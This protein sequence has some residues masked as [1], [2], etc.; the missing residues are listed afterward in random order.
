MYPGASAEDRGGRANG[1]LERCAARQV[2]H[3]GARG[4]WDVDLG[5][6]VGGDGDLEVELPVGR[7]AC[8]GPAPGDCNLPPDRL[9]AGAKVGECSRGP[10]LDQNL[11]KA[12]GGRV[13]GRSVCPTTVSP[14][15]ISPLHHHCITAIFFVHR[16]CNSERACYFCLKKF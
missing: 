16:D 13:S 1:G 6:D 4:G 8:R 2:D 3:G 9:E 14:C 15:S 5:T 10:G 12:L 7:R 11:V